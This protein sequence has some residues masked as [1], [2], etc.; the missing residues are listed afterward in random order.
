MPALRTSPILIAAA[1]TATLAVAACTAGTPTTVTTLTTTAPAAAPGDPAPSSAAPV[2]RAVITIS[3]GDAATGASVIDPVVV[4]A[5]DGTLDTVAVTNPEGREVEGALS[6]DG[7]T[8]TSAE[9]LGYGR[10]YRIDAVARDTAGLTTARSSS[11]TT[12]APAGV[13]FP[14]FEPP[15]DR[16]VVGV[17]H[18]ISVIFDK[19]PPDRAAAERAV[20]VTTVPAQVGGWYW[21][22]ERTMHYRPQVYWQAGTQITVDAKVYGVD[23][24]GGF[25]G[26]TDRTLNLTIGPSKIA[27]VDDATKI[28]TVTIDGQVARQF[29][30][31]MGRDESITV[32]GKVISFVTPSGIY[33]AQEKYDVKQMNSGSYGLP[34]SFDL[35]YDSAIPLAVRLSN[36]GIFAH[37][38]P[39]SVAD[40]GIRNVSH[41]CINMPPADA[42]WFY[43]TFSYGDVVQ[44]T[45]TSTQLAPD[46]GYGDWNVG[47]EQ[48]LQGSALT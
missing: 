36:S 14:S 12:V 34:A 15:P 35:G 2:S 46:D 32:D 27:T 23:L 43:D 37:S 44:V 16:G 25:Y 47:W 1:L 29:P 5:A 40:Q 28:M 41:G 8:W 4:T 6:T 17:G 19:A 7:T 48:W 20:T 18:P 39:W 10:T 45:G 13:I 24:G 31:S 38:A 22:D 26:E 3:P 9:P 30:V 42:Q 11:F 21:L 33:V